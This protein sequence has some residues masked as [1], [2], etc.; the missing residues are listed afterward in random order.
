MALI[1]TENLRY[2][3][4]VKFELAPELAF[5]REQVTANEASAKSYVVGTVLGKVTATGKFK[6]SVAT[7]TDGSE[8][9]AAVVVEDKAV[10]AATDTKVLALVRGPAIVGKAGLVLDATIDTQAEKDAV[11]AALAAKGILANDQ[12]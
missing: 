9:A 6:V 8:V 5:C 1:G 10:A 11:Y 3:N 2:S 4:V 7:A 12:F